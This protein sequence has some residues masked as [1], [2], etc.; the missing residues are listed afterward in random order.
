MYDSVT[1][2]IKH[3]DPIFDFG[4]HRLRELVGLR[5]TVRG[6]F[7]SVHHGLRR[8]LQDA[9]SCIHRRSCASGLHCIESFDWRKRDSCMGVTKNGEHGMRV[10]VEEDMVC[11]TRPAK[12]LNL[13]TEE[14]CQQ[15]VVIQ[16]S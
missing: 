15:R 14:R 2:E 7:H 8:E 13:F 4:K 9:R 3:V 16:I 11:P 10:G 12:R 1:R 6:I 5:L